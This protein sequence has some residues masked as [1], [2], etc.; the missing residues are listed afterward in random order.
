MIGGGAMEC[1]FEVRA[2]CLLFP[3]IR[4]PMTGYQEHDGALRH[5]KASGL[6]LAYS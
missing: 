5:Y 1:A 2:A 3:E 6:P 4:Y